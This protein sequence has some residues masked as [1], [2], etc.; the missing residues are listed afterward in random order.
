[1]KLLR[2]VCGARAVLGILIYPQVNCGSC[3]PHAPR[4]PSLATL[5]RHLP[6][7][8]G[9]VVPSFEERDE[10]CAPHAPRRPSLATL[11]RYVCAT[12]SGPGAWLLGALLLLGA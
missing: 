8:P 4:R 11:R 7:D 3:A 6:H 5:Q 2:S 10:R 9:A 1:M 12:L